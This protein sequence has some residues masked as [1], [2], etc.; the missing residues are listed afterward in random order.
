MVIAGT[1]DDPLWNLKSPFS[2]LTA[3]LDRL[4]NTRRSCKEDNTREVL[5]VKSVHSCTALWKSSISRKPVLEMDNEFDD[6]TDNRQDKPT[7]PTQMQRAIHESAH[8]NDTKQM[9]DLGYW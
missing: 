8:F 6:N 1:I 3:P 7:R 9:N 4:N 5:A 2:T